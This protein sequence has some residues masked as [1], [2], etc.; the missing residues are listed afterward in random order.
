MAL[1]RSARGVRDVHVPRRRD[2]AARRRLGHGGGGRDARHGHHDVRQVRHLLSGITHT[3][4]HT[5]TLRPRS[6]MFSVQ[7]GLGCLKTDNHTNTFTRIPPHTH[8]HQLVCISQRADRA[9]ALRGGRLGR[10]RGAAR[11][12]GQLRLRDPLRRRRPPSRVRRHAADPLRNRVQVPTHTHTHRHTHAHTHACTYARTHAHTHLR[13]QTDRRIQRS[14]QAH[15]LS[16]TRKKRT[17]RVPQTHRPG[18]WC[19]P[20]SRNQS[21]NAGFV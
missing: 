4:T 18:L 5:H 19:V 2:A 7:I 6:F 12:A 17:H 21:I 10:V 1:C 16:Y 15:T 14:T 11:G 13:V 20:A 3:H 9:D 8:T